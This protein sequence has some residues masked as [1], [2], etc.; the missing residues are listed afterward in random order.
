[1]LSAVR[2]IDKLFRVW[3]RVGGN[4]SDRQGHCLRG[5]CL[6]GYRYPSHWQMNGTAERSIQLQLAEIEM[7]VRND[8]ELAIDGVEGPKSCARI[9]AIPYPVRAFDIGYTDGCEEV[10]E[11]PLNGLTPQSLDFYLPPRD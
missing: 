1:M 9:E 4:C 11:T 6:C 5:H 2:A 3:L 10:Y 7:A 8:I